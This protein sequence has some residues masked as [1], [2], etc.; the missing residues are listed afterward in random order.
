MQIYHLEPQGLLPESR[1]FLLKH[2]VVFPKSHTYS[3]F[4]KFFITM[5]KERNQNSIPTIY[6]LKYSFVHKYC[7]AALHSHGCV[8]VYRGYWR[9][10]RKCYRWYR[11]LSHLCQKLSPIN[12]WAVL[13]KT[14]IPAALAG[15]QCHFRE[16]WNYHRRAA[17]GKMKIQKGLRMSRVWK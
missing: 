11:R 12:T 9:V 7:A 3:A 5:Y 4:S 8:T 2:N 1:Y 13:A 10:I 17:V 6:G 15:R 14:A 16:A